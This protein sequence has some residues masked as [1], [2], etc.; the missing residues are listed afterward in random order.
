MR[1]RPRRPKA[2]GRARGCDRRSRAA[3]TARRSASPAPAAC[4]CS[5]RSPSRRCPRCAAA[6]SKSSYGSATSHRA[7]RTSSARSPP[8]ASIAGAPM[9][10]ASTHA[11]SVRMRWGAPQRAPAL[12]APTSRRRYARRD[13]SRAGATRVSSSR[14]RH[15][16]ERGEF[17]AGPGGAHPPARRRAAPRDRGR[18][19]A[20]L[21]RMPA[22]VSPAMNRRW[23]YSRL[24]CGAHLGAGS[25]PA[26]SSSRWAGLWPQS[27]GFLGQVDHALGSRRVCAVPAHLRYELLEDVCGTLHPAQV[28]V[29]RGPILLRRPKLTDFV[30]RSPRKPDDLPKMV[31]FVARAPGA[32]KAAISEARLAQSARA[33]TVNSCRAALGEVLSEPSSAPLQ[34]E[35]ATS[36]TSRVT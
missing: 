15:C 35:T 14:A 21:G 19:P 10:A 7:S 3:C 16:A 24:P 26:R 22:V 23:C 13:G 28:I 20:A 27:G 11:A 2:A 1:G 4:G 9:H 12:F 8:A 25:R 33:L 36:V 6:R 29:D 5:R 18:R 17:P 31:R 34:P 32:G 30:G